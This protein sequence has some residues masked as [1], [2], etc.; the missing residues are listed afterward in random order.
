MLFAEV[1]APFDASLNTVE[2]LYL[3]SKSLPSNTISHLLVPN[4]TDWLPISISLL[5]TSKSPANCGE[6][7]ADK[8][9]SLSDKR[10]DGTVPD[11]RLLADNAVKSAC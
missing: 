6:L 1:T 9:V 11:V 8:S 4:F 5:F 10:A 2:P 7:S 3:K